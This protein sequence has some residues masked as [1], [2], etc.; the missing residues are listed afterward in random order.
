[1]D[2]YSEAHAL[3]P[4]IRN[5][6]DLICRVRPV[7]GRPNDFNVVFVGAGNMM[8]GKPEIFHNVL[9]ELSTLL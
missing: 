2:R 5:S 1:M 6:E 7:V 3:K 4:E 9:A 8:F